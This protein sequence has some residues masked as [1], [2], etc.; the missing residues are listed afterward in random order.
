V[1]FGGGT[2]SYLSSDQILSLVDRIQRHWTWEHAA[3][4]SFECEP[5]TLRKS[6]L[7]T[8]RRIGVTRLSLGIEHFDDDVLVQNGRAHRSPEVFRA[9]HW[10]REVGFPQINI[11]LIAGMIGDDDRK[12]DDAVDK[13]LGLG[14]DSVTIYQMEVPQNTLMAREAGESGHAAPVVSWSRKRDWVDRAFRRFEQAGY[15]VNS[16][17]TVMKKQPEAQFVYRDLV[18]RGADMI[19]TGAAS[20][21]HV[22]GVHFQNADR[23]ETYVQG[24]LADSA[25]PM[26]RARVMTHVQR[27]IREFVLQLKL[28][29]VPFAYFQQKFQLCPGQMFADTLEQLAKRG[30]L[31]VNSEH[32]ELTRHGLLCADAIVPEFF[33]AQF[34]DDR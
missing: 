19:G 10:A 24:L 14:A 9:F 29:Q 16:A 21:S 5:G 32:V 25:L 28:G 23:W 18:W 2:P 15:V 12:W 17:Y 20:F 26:A 1:Y 7:E 4:V 11:D 22:N 31:H 6:K 13:A 34:R 27:F 3:E 30:Y 8:I 33:E